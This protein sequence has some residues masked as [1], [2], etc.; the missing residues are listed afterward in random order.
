MKAKN[1]VMVITI[2]V[3]AH[4]SFWDAL[5]MRLAGIPNMEAMKQMDEKAEE[6]EEETKRTTIAK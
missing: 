4:L 2:A 5:K 1:E 3:K 6:K